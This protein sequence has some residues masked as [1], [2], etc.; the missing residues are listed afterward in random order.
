LTLQLQHCQRYTHPP[1]PPPSPSNHHS[2]PC[3]TAALL[4]KL[5]MVLLSSMAMVIGPTPPGTGVIAPAV[6][7]A[8]E[9]TS[10]TVRF[11]AATLVR[12]CHTSH[13]TRRKS[14]VASHTSHVTRHTSQVTRHTSR[15]TRQ[16]AALPVF[17]EGSGMLLMPTSMT[18]APGLIQD[19]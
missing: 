7:N 2:P 5:V 1:P 15:V 13:V 6:A 4:L 16:T 8:S 9:D 12:T 19:A 17:F 11:P 10:P 3:F 18:T 14:H